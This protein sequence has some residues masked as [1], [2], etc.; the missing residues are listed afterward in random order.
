MLRFALDADKTAAQAGAGDA[1][2]CRAAE[3]VEN[4]VVG[5]GRRGD[6]APEQGFR[7]LGGVLA[8]SLFTFARRLDVP[9]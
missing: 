9:E 7:F 8:V 5:I 1:G 2:G 4:Q 6:N 3:G